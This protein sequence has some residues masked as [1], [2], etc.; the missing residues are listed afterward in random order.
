VIRRALLL[1][2]A[3]LVPGLAPGPAEA[4]VPES[5]R[6]EVEHLLEYVRLSGCTFIRNGR[7]Y[8][9]ERAHRH[10][11]R[12]YN[13]FRDEI[14]STERFIELAATEST[15]SGRPYQIACAETARP[16]KDVLLEELGRFRRAP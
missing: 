6:A 2:A 16:S 12:K 5:Q 7:E 8:D 15:M 14:D 10:V 11:M 4:D 9:G 3:L 1:S 13:Y